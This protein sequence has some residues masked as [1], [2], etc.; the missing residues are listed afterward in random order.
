MPYFEDLRSYIDALDE[1]GDLKRISREVDGDL[2]PGAITR[3][4]CEIQSAAPLFENIRGAKP[5]FRVLGAPAA[6]SSR[7]DMRY[8]RV[9]LSL[10]LPANTAGPDIV[11]ALAAARTAKQYPPVLVESSE[12]LC[13]QNILRGDDANLDNFPIPFAHQQDGGRY[14]NTWGAVIVKTP[15]GRWVNWAITRIMKIDGKRMTGLIV[16]SQHLGQVWAE[17]VKLG[18]PMPYALVQ[19]AAPA[20][21]CVAGIPLPVGANEVDYVGALHGEPVKLVKAVSVDLEVPATA[22][23]VIEGHVSLTRDSMEGPY[24]E[25]GGYMGTKSFLQPTFHVETITHRDNPVW[26]LVVAG[27]PA[28][29]THTIWSMGLAA[30]ALVHLR[31][32]GLPIKS[33]WIPEAAA[34]HWL[35]VSVPSDWRKKL[36]GVSSEEFARR[37]GEAIFKTDAMVWLPKVFLIDDDIDPTNVADF[38]W[39]ISTRVH[40]TGRRAVFD[41]QRITRL[42]VCYTE[43]DFEKVRAPKIVYDTL[44]PALEDGRDGHASF[45]QSY[46][47]ELRKRVLANW[48]L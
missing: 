44:Q 33:A 18:Q 45:E 48:D 8:A 41:D 43:E 11:E 5:G 2:E 23:I 36:P 35:L 20:I 21:S 24:G 13:H 12:A 9:A 10:G 28:D 37:V 26:P 19:G 40:P 34:V 1:I 3:R 25:Y 29:E 39:A 14:A 42:S 30:D 6:V 46:P 17:W 22:E 7:A 4:S 47:E 16:P 32:A 15:D 38:V 31:A 27:R